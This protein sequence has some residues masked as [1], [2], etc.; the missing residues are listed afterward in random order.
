MLEEII[1]EA[2][3]FDIKAFREEAESLRKKCL[4]K[5]EVLK[6]KYFEGFRDAM[7]IISESPFNASRL[8]E[9]LEEAEF[10]REEA[11]KAGLKAMCL[12]YTGFCE[13]IGKY[14]Q[15]TFGKEVWIWKLNY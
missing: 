13:A 6:S 4:Q 15:I 1:K 2:V 10:I 12:Y 14:L 11:E 7:D 9:I 8:Q 3:E 5:K